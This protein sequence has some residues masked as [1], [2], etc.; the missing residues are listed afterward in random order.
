MTMVRAL[1]AA[2]PSAVL[3]ALVALLALCAPADRALAV[4]PVAHRAPASAPVVTSGQQ[5]A[6]PTAHPC[7]HGYYVSRAA[8]AGKGGQYVSAIARS[9]LGKNGSCTAP[10]PAQALSTSPKAAS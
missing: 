10:L 9:A 2:R 3:A 7:N 1:P 8:H 6:A 5:Q 4:Q